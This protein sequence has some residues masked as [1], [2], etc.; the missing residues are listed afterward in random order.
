[1]SHGKLLPSLF[2]MIA[3]A[4]AAIT[5]VALT[6]VALQPPSAQARPGAGGASVRASS[7]NGGAPVAMPCTELPRLSECRELA[8]SMSEALQTEGSRS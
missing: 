8:R 4:A 2:T 3:A 7:S 6:S 5:I 1:V